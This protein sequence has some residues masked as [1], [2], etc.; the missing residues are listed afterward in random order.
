MY[1]SVGGISQ[2]DVA[3]LVNGG[4]YKG[5]VN[6]L[7]GVHGAL[8][9]TWTSDASLVA[10]DMMRFGTIPGVNV[11]NLEEMT[12]AEITALLNG[13]GTTIGAFCNSGVCLAGLR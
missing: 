8:D 3:P 4:L 7:T 12:S 11:Y 10:D 9:G 5:D 6:I 2:N 1:T 13:P